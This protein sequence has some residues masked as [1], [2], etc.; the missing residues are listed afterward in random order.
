ML[1][2][3][4]ERLQVKTWKEEDWHDFYPISSDPEVV[5]HV[6]D[7]Q[8]FSEEKTKQWVRRQITK[9]A[10]QGFCRYQLVHKE[11]Q[12]LCG[13][14]GLDYFGTTGDVEIG[15]WIARDQWGKGLATEAAHAVLRHAR[16]SLALAR[17]IS[18]CTL[19]NFGSRR[20][21]EKIGLQLEK[22][23]PVRELGIDLDIP[24][25]VYAG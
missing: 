9:Q 23:A 10:E 4:T 8:P 14:C 19:D 16:E 6:G 21:M 1:I 20:V 12:K 24:V 25:V 15:Y 7:G 22:E 17:V 13:W 11:Q 2:C 5:R 3:E 18:V